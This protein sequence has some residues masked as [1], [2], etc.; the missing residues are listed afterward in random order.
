MT[1]L[2]AQK[3]KKTPRHGLIKW[4][5]LRTEYTYTHAHKDTTK[6]KWIHMWMLNEKKKIQY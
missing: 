5:K 1:N 4:S 2:K 6:N 3:K